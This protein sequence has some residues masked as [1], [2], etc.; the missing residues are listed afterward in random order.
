MA[1]TDII[2][3]IQ[4]LI[5]EIWYNKQIPIDCKIICPIIEKEDIGLVSNYSGIFL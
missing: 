2:I 4:S 3:E 5:K 1:E